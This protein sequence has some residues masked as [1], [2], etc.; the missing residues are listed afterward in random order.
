M[1]T[2]KLTEMSSNELSGLALKIKLEKLDE[3]AE[4]HEWNIK[5]MDVLYRLCAEKFHWLPSEVRSLTDGELVAVL[6]HLVKF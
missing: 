2:K 4:E 6:G 3:Y 5:G 1:P